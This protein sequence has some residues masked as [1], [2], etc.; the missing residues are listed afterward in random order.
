MKRGGYTR[1]LKYELKFRGSSELYETIKGIS[2][3]KEITVAAV[4]RKLVG[5]ALRQRQG[6]SNELSQA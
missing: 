5:E 3:Q 4:L 1:D 2:S 6:K